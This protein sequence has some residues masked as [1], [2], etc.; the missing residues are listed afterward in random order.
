M[1]A[2][3]YRALDADGRRTRGIISAASGAA[4]RAELR[5]RRLS[6]L[7]VDRAGTESRS[8]GRFSS[9]RAATV[10]R[11]MPASA[12]L[13]MTRQLATLTGAGLP[14]AEALNIVASQ[15]SHVASRRIII[16]LR[17]RVLEG[18]RLSTAMQGFAASFPPVYRAMVAAGES[19]GAL[20]TVLDRLAVYLEKSAA[21]SRKVMTA[22]IYP[23]A[24]A[25]TAMAVIAVLMVAIV[26]RLAEQF[27][28]MSITLPALTRAMIA[29]SSFLQTGWPWLLAGIFAAI[30]GVRL[31]AR[32]PAV[33]ARLDALS[34]SVPVL[35]GF[36]RKV[37]AARFARTLSVLLAAGT[38]LPDALRAA[39]RATTN[40]RIATALDGVVSEVEGGKP[41]S[42]ALEGARFLPALT[43]HMIAAGERSAA[44]ETMLPRAADQLDG[45]LEAASATALSLL[46]PAI[47]IIMGALV[48]LIVLSI[49]LPILQLNTLALN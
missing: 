1:P 15:T 23:C 36:L 4:A 14:L 21:L 34:L 42:S 13:L 5:R 8:S 43:L 9:L 30:V 40:T 41:L 17:E 12:R 29:L 45:E 11:S 44:L 38:V 16:A 22:L 2:F 6:P 19:S 48:A 28:T 25:V 37:E 20:G 31:L 26:P 27:D 7:S 32:R 18:E 49:L 3:E 46:E 35:G 10:S 33:K 24:L 47:I 39:R